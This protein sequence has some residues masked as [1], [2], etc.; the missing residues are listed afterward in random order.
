MKWLKAV[1]VV[2]GLVLAILTALP[3]VIRLDHYIPDIENELAAKLKEPVKISGIRFSALPMPN[4][5]LNGISLGKEQDVKL[6][7][8]IVTPEILSLAR[9][10]KV[11]RSIEVESLVL[12]QRTLGMLSAWSRPQTMGEP[13]L[14][15]ENIVISNAVVD[16]GQVKLGPFNARLRMDEKGAPRDAVLTQGDGNLKL[17]VTPEKGL[18]QFEASATAWKP[19]LGPAVQ[20][21]ELSVKGV[22]TLEGA[23]LNELSAK[24]YGGTVHG[25]AT[26]G[27]QSGWQVK[28][29]L[30][31]RGMELR[32]L[33]RL[34]GTAVRASGKLSA[35]PEFS[36][37]AAAAAQ[38][39]GALRLAAPFNVES[40]VLQGVDL[41]KGALS[42]VGQKSGG[43]ETRFDQLTGHLAVERGAYHFTKLNVVSGV[44]AAHGSVDISATKALTGQ[45]DARLQ[46]AMGS[47][48]VPLNVAGTTSAPLLYPTRASLAG[49]AVGSAVLGPGLGTA[50]GA[51]VGSWAEKLLGKQGDAKK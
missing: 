12:T 5:A 44:L 17:L 26:L 49:A 15:I 35:Q 33:T 41:Q 51:A 29:A 27:W 50:A 40:G 25:N 1:A 39:A 9:S 28:G 16:L 48:S 32:E 45:L 47:A 19:P 14:R 31:I 8:V 13:A 22:A 30:D 3:F 18:Y 11:I 38:L 42:L 23:K 6:G 24:L 7:K 20:F 4:V 36:S 21:D 2:C 37:S 43:G 10:T 46:T 34:S